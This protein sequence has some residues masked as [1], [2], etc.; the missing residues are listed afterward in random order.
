MNF[1]VNYLK[2]IYR[3]TLN[4]IWY[5][6]KWNNRLARNTSAHCWQPLQLKSVFPGWRAEG[7]FPKSHWWSRAKLLGAS[8]FGG[9]VYSSVH[10]LD[11]LWKCV[12]SRNAGSRELR[13]RNFAPP[14][15]VFCEIIV[16]EEKRVFRLNS[17]S[18]MKLHVLIVFTFITFEWFIQWG[19]VLGWFDFRLD[20]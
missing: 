10:R 9:P 12:L 14:P 11:A 19:L 16:R 13:L 3:P 8:I 5:R 7:T 4:N 17:G 15:V 18:D 20:S 1:L 6:G 2:N